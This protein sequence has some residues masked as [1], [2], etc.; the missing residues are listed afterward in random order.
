MLFIFLKI[1]LKEKTMNKYIFASGNANKVKEV[2]EMIGNFHNDAVVISLKDIGF[3]GD[4]EENG[5]TF[6]ENATIKAK[7]IKEFLNKTHTYSDFSILADD[8]GLC[9]DS[10]NGEPGIYSARYGGD[11][12]FD[13]NRK[14]LLDN[15][16]DKA[17][18]S[19][20]YFCS[21]VL[22]F[23]DGTL[24]SSEG[25]T[26]G[27]ILKEKTGDSGFCY[28]PFFYSFDLKKSFGQASDA[29]KNSVSHRARALVSLMQKENEY[30]NEKQK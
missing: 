18:R 9:V 11:H 30:Y 19:A 7:A 17:D 5:T 24:I 20:H 10:L 27:E 23:P 6:L 8:S 4:I 28:D 25:K 16:K 21:M 29:E 2:N 12:N 13:L 15:L 26:F 14:K 1:S 3:S 22:I